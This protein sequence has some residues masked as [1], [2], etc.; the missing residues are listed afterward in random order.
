M[1]DELQAKTTHE[2]H[3][4]QP[5]QRRGSVRRGR[6]GRGRGGRGCGNPSSSRDSVSKHR[7]K[8]PCVV[9][10]SQEGKYR[11]PCC[12]RRFCSKECFQ[13]HS[14]DDCPIKKRRLDHEAELKAK[15]DKRLQDIAQQGGGQDGDDED[16][17]LTDA[18]RAALRASSSVRGYLD[19]TMMR[20]VLRKICTAPN[21]RAALSGFLRDPHFS[22]FVDEVM[23]VLDASSEPFF[24]R[25]ASSSSCTME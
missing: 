20:N 19:D 16:V 15:E 12:K 18:H 23:K 2:R 10:E 11:F 3:P 8:D 7:L 5:H 22:A 25:Q 6:G 24:A 1:P 21:K 9:C 14:A 17:L 4:Q 13:R